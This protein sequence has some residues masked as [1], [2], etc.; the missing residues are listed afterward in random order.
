MTYRNLAFNYKKSLFV[1]FENDDA[2]TT[3][4]EKFVPYQLQHFWSRFRSGQTVNTYRCN[5][6]QQ[7]SQTNADFMEI[8]LSFPQDKKK[9]FE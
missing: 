1:E 2:I 3:E 8:I 6:C 7:I 9:I 5:H 4:D